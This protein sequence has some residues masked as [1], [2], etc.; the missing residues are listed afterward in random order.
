MLVKEQDLHDF[1]KFAFDRSIVRIDSSQRSIEYLMSARECSHH[2]HE[3]SKLAL[4][5]SMRGCEHS[6]NPIERSWL[7]I[8]SSERNC[9]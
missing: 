5:R 7:A 1:S 9:E 8:D 2:A 6:W 3:F 4:G